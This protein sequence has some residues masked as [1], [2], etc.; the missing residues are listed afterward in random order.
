MNE[1]FRVYRKDDAAN[2]QS[3]GDAAYERFSEAFAPRADTG[4]TAARADRTDRFAPPQTEK[5]AREK[6]KDKKRRSAMREDNRAEPAALREVRP[7]KKKGGARAAVIAVAAL[8]MCA[9]LAAGGWLF[10]RPEMRPRVGLKAPVTSLR[11]FATTA[12]SEGGAANPEPQRLDDMV[13]LEELYDSMY[14]LTVEAGTRFVDTRGERYAA[15]EILEKL[16]AYGYTEENGRI[17]DQPFRID[18]PVEVEIEEDED[19]TET[20]TE[21]AIEPLPPTGDPG[22]SGEDDDK[23]K[24][25][26]VHVYYD[27]RNLIATLPTAVPDPRILV[28]SCHYD[29]V[30]DVEGAVDNAS[31]CATVLEMARVMAASGRD[32]GVEIRFIFFSGE[33]LGLYG[34]KHYIEELSDAE[35]ARHLGQLNIDMAG[36]SNGDEQHVFTVST[37]GKNTPDGYVEGT[38]DQPADNSV[39]LAV[40]RAYAHNT[41]GIG[42]FISPMHWAKNDLKPFHW[43]GIDAVTLSW[44]EID[45]SRAI[46]WD[47]ASPSVMHTQWDTLSNFNVTTLGETARLALAA[48]EEL[49]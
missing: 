19:E 12:Q 5:P 14:R 41:F 11:A 2:G 37:Y 39:S 46:V 20:E 4:N 45:A 7:R 33:E 28:V 42:A 29:A 34:S 47:I 21:G 48:V 9:L 36:S 31:G 8:L 26:I 27:S 30:W 1:K 25:K 43:A 16:A 32:F 15:G 17:A 13:S 38:T 40:A 6:A 49:L 44:R 18:I 24:T 22:G 10:L 35:T 3:V 23:P